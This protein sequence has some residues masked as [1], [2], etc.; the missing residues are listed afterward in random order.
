M[1][2]LFINSARRWGGNEKWTQQAAEGLSQ[3]GH[4][5]FLAYRHEAVGAR[6]EANVLRRRFPFW[7]ELDLWTIVRLYV[8]A[9]RHHIEVMIPT[10]PKEYFIAGLLRRILPAK[11][12]LRLGIVREVHRTF[13]QRLI[14]RKWADGIIVNA[15]AI[16]ESLIKRSGLP[17]NKVRLIHNGY[18]QAPTTRPVSPHEHLRKQLSA[19]QFIIAYLGELSERK[20]CEILLEHFARLSREQQEKR[21][22]LCLIGDGDRRLA[23]QKHVEHLNISDRVIFTGFIEE[24]RPL[25]HAC[26][27][28]ALLSNNEG[29][30][31]AML[32][33]MACGLPVIVTRAGSAAEVINDGENGFLLDGNDSDQFCAIIRRLHERPGERQA[34]GQRARET[35]AR[36]FSNERMLGEIEA[37]LLQTLARNE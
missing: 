5:V 3:R 33:A 24:P 37:F 21:C 22:G 36:K 15:E 27:V 31:N 35:V 14:Y 29:I 11:N 6:F 10:K 20:G 19:F 30:S 9:S 1:N 12:V 4:R 2:I 8:W 34:I 26:Q 7:F 18:L 16:Q 13:W 17:A 23:L 32:E 25:L 28:F